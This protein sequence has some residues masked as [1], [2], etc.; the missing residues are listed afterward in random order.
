[1]NVVTVVNVALILVT[2]LFGVA[3]LS[4]RKGTVRQAHARNH[5]ETRG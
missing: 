5:R 3:V 4:P 2:L 1:M